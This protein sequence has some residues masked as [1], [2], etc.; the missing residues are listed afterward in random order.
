ML[1]T[2]ELKKSL[3]EMRD[4]LTSVNDFFNSLVSNIALS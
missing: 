1:D 3:A 4:D 2:K